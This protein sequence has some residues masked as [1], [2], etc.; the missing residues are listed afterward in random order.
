MWY[1]CTTEFYLVVKEDDVVI[2]EGKCIELGN[3]L[4]KKIQNQKAKTTCSSPVWI[5]PSF[6]CKHVCI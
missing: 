1:I 2:F 5:D 3:I 4:S 6:N